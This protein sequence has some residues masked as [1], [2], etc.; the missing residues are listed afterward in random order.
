M[1][2]KKVKLI[3]SFRPEAGQEGLRKKYIKLYASGDEVS[4]PAFTYSK[5]TIGTL[6]KGV[7]YVQN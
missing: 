3:F 6:E 7:K 4:Q 2:P 5:S 1:V